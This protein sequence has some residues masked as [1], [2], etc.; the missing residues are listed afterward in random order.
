MQSLLVIFFLLLLLQPSYLEFTV[1]MPDSSNLVDSPQTGFSTRARTDP[2]EQRAV[3]EIMAATGNTWASSIP[4]VCRGRWHGIECMPDS[5]DVYHVVSLS[6]GALSDDTAFPTCDDAPQGGATLSSAVLLL[7]HLRSLFFYR[8]LDANP[9]PIPA[10]LGRLGPTLRSL[11]LRDNGHVGPIP[12]ELGN[13][14]SLRVLDLHGNRLEDSIPSSFS[15]LISLQLLDLSS[16]QLSGVVP[17]LNS[18]SLSVLDL[19]HNHLHCRI[20]SSLSKCESLLKIDLSQ[21]RFIGLIPD[22]LRSL[23]NLILL[24]LSHNSLSGGLPCSTKNGY[25][26]LQALILKGNPMTSAT[27]PEDCFAGMKELNTLILSGM[28]L[29]GPMPESMS[30]LR[31][32]RVLHLEGNSLNGSIP[33][34]FRRLD[35]LS[36]LRLDDNRLVG[37]IPFEREMMWR[38][39]TKL[40]VSNN[41]GLCLEMENGGGEGLESMA[42]ITYC[43]PETMRTVGEE[44]GSGA[45]TKHLSVW[46]VGGWRPFVLRSAAEKRAREI[47]RDLFFIGT[48]LR[49]LVV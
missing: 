43:D 23:K 4:D 27:I 34:N 38:M 11:V 31:S 21:N 44:K 29:E 14:T 1:V 47:I 20:P 22:S 46:N 28:G 9:H 39:G 41:S 49:I 16:N 3:Y 32:L 33:G 45:E 12:P 35:K 8:C 36:E 19:N 10:F 42:G 2:N 15:S 48:V 37:R 30:E 25:V 13:L 7:P 40:R 24:D 6:F 18:P 5:D 26:S 17:E